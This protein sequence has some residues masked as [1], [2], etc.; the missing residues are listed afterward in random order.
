[1]IITNIIKKG[2]KLIKETNPY[3]NILNLILLLYMYVIIHFIL[4]VPDFLFHI[5]NNYISNTISL[6][7]LLHH[8]N[9]LFL[10]LF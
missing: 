9:S 4:F 6:L 10:K 5:F 1:M 7:N 3:N 8:E 2:E